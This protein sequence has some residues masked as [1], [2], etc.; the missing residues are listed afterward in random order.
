V[1]I[2]SNFDFLTNPF[3]FKVFCVVGLN[4]V[5]KNPQNLG[6]LINSFAFALSLVNG[7]QFKMKGFN[8]NEEKKGQKF[9][10]T[11]KTKGR[12]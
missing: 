1:S 10:T 3:W 7:P 12:V 6:E 8:T 4:H 11:Q 2:L 5:W 9:L